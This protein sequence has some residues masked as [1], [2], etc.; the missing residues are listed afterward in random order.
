MRRAIMLIIAMLGMTIVIATPTK[1][2]SGISL[3]DDGTNWGSSLSRPLFDETIRWVPGDVR[4]A[5]FYIRSDAP[6][7]TKLDV[8]LFSHAKH[9]RMGRDVQL[10]ARVGDA[11]WQPANS[12]GNALLTV[13]P[14]AP[15]SK[16]RIEVRASFAGRSTNR[17][18]RLQL[19]IRL[20]IS[21]T[22]LSGV[23]TAAANPRALASTGP[24]P[25]TAGL[26]IAAGAVLYSIDWWRRSH[27]KRKEVARDAE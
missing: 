10:E 11:E 21:L 27:A 17:P 6:V 3:S 8:E 5:D 12:F 1:D 22:P 25:L 7:A 26:A 2:S 19:E 24:V 4:T 23:R 18:E 14:M 20:Q 15:R 9:A 16:V 13:Q